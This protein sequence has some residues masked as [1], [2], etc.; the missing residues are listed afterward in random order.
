MGTHSPGAIQTVTLGSPVSPRID[1]RTRTWNLRFWRPLLYQLSYAHR[2]PGTCL[3]PRGYGAGGSSWCWS[4]LRSGRRVEGCALCP[5]GAAAVIAGSRPVWWCPGQGVNG[6]CPAPGCSTMTG[7]ATSP[8]ACHLPD[9]PAGMNA[10]ESPRPSP[11][12][13]E[14]QGHACAKHILT[15][16]CCTTQD[17]RVH[18]SGQ[19]APQWS[20]SRMTLQVVWSARYRTLASTTWTVAPDQWMMSEVSASQSQLVSMSWSSAGG[21]CQGWTLMVPHP[22]HSVSAVNGRGGYRVLMRWATVFHRSVRTGGGARLHRGRGRASSLR[23]R[24]S[25]RGSST[26]GR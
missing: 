20:H 19:E 15:R 23:C 12:S 13:G 14:D 21:R 6:L 3:A 16:V 17:Q 7:D 10:C 5:G 4:R 26:I 1:A 8:R 25:C 24:V 11:V 22:G 18:R 9:R 2:H